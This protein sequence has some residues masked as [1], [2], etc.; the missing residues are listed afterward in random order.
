MKIKHKINSFIKN[1]F[2]GVNVANISNAVNE[3]T[4]YY[5]FGP[6]KPRVT[7]D[8]DWVIIEIDTKTIASQNNEYQKVIYLC[9]NG[10]YSEAKPLLKMLIDRN[11]TI[12]EYHRIY[13]QILSDEGNTDEAINSLIDALRWDPNNGYALLMMGNIFAR[14]KND[15]STAMK[16]YDQALAINPNDHIAVNNIG[17]NMMQQ[18]KIGEA[19]K[20]LE[21]ALNINDKYPNT[22]FALGMIAE[23]ENDLQNSFIYSITALKLNKTKDTLYQNSVRQAVDVA[24]RII[25]K[26]EGKKI[27]SEFTYALETESNKTI[28]VIEDKQIPTAAKLELAENY[29]RV[30]HIV[31]Y[32]PTFP[33][34]EHLI[35]HELMHLELVIEARKEAVNLLFTSTQEHKREFIKELLP[36]INKLSKQGIPEESIAQYCNGLFEGLNR[37]IFNTPVDLFIEDRIHNRYPLFR[38]YQF[39]SLFNLV[40]DGLKAVTD[41]KVVEL[42]PKDILS[43]SKIYNL[44]NA[45]QLRD[46]YGIDLVDDFMATQKE[47]EESKGFYEEYLQYKDDKAPAEE[48]ELVLHWAED[49]NIES[50]FEL[51]SENEYR[52]KRTNIDTLLDSIEKDPFGLRNVDPFKQREMDK[53]QESQK[54]NGLNMAVVMFMI[55]ALN[56]FEGKDKEYIKKVAFEIAMQ[57]THGYKPEKKDYRISSISEKLFSGYHILAYY[58]ISWSLSIPDKVADLKIPYD[59]EY[60]LALKMYKSPTN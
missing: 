18:G 1:I 3:F 60:E 6:I 35:I 43:K 40:K 36:T 14:E 2:P 8:G 33:A 44:V 55:D 7:I 13:G 11:P 47:L 29:N 42:S 38:P 17:A 37:Q 50:S 4:D 31:R 46:L 57:G 52:S 32:N 16:Y 48:Y 45:F 39:I 54:S 10:K 9:E 23:M 30:E 22:L 28:N 56:H 15:I 41:K 49:L 19:K 12:S 34:I 26:R 24:N 51:I 58:Y 21:A 27:V 20:Y 59:R 25:A 53:F 5:S